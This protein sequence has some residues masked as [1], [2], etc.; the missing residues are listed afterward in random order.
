[1]SA[2]ADLITVE[3]YVQQEK[4]IKESAL[5]TGVGQTAKIWLSEKFLFLVFVLVHLN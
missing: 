2:N 5:S 3:T 1:M 4:T